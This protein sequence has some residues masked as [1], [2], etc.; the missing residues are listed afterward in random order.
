MQPGGVHCRRQ[1]TASDPMATAAGASWWLLPSV[2][3]GAAITALLCMVTGPKRHALC[4][5]KDLL[6]AS[7]EAGVVTVLLLCWQPHLV[8]SLLLQYLEYG[9]DLST[10]T[11]A[12]RYRPTQQMT[13][14]NSTTGPTKGLTIFSGKLLVLPAGLRCSARLCGSKLGQ[15]CCLGCAVLVCTSL[16]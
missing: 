11:H 13:P 9:V 8:C 14:T 3:L 15:D 1:D 12:K 7:R 16:A 6:A 10:T 5:P 4:S 2:A